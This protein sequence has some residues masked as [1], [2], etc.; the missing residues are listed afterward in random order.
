MES[1]QIR[2]FFLIR[3]FPFPTRKKSIFAHFSHSDELKLSSEYDSIND[4][5]QLLV[6][7]FKY[8]AVR[9]SGHWSMST[10]EQPEKAVKYV[11]R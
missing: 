11:Q 4:Y 6:V 7:S 1:S 3:I 2:F 9:P 5:I 10:I 8:M